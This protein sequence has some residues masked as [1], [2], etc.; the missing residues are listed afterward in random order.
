MS[1]PPVQI[2]ELNPHVPEVGAPFA[3]LLDADDLLWRDGGFM[4]N[5][6]RCLL[7]AGCRYFVCAGSRGEELHDR[8]DDLI[9]EDE[10][11][12]ITT[13]FHD[14]ESRPDVIEFFLLCALPGM[15]GGLVFV[16]DT[17]GWAKLP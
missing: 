14:G 8:I 3:V 12:G 17:L 9:V 2:V 16:Q 11:T 5:T 10:Y 6:V 1:S 13:T 7:A 15:T 4:D